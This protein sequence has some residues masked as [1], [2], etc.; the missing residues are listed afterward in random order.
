L[1][2]RWRALSDASVGRKLA[3]LHETVIAVI[4]TIL[5]QQE[6]PQ[7]WRR[8]LE[9]P[10]VVARLLNDADQAIR[11]A[12]RRRLEW[13][14]GDA[15]LL[16]TV[17]TEAASEIVSSR[18]V[19]DGDDS[20][21]FVTLRRQL[22][23]QGRKASDVATALQKTLT[24]TLESLERSAPAPRSDIGPLRSAALR[25]LPPVDLEALRHELR[26]TRPWWASLAPALAEWEQ[27]RAIQKR[28]GPTIGDALRRHQRR[29]AAWIDASVTRL[30]E[31]YEA[32]AEVIR[33]Q[34]RRMTADAHDFD[35]DAARDQLRDA[36][37]EL[38]E[39]RSMK[40]P[41]ENLIDAANASESS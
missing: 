19:T 4:E 3:Q 6:G 20:P 29:L 28:L 8:R 14:E 5:A 24:R 12:Q 36:L 1:F 18:A 38:R 22:I 37:R 17:V 41:M 25:E 15:A 9:D 32:Q 13:S 11:E 35:T 16:E 33:E 10:S 39:A 31:L 34:S 21:V 23:R 30:V 7:D 2:A 27:R 26:W 40:E